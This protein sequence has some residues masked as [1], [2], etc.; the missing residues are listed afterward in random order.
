MGRTTDIDQLQ[1][2]IETQSEGAI[3]SLTELKKALS[4]LKR[5]GKS[6]ELDNLATKLEK[7]SKIRFDNLKQI[8]M[9]GETFKQVKRLTKDVD[10]LK[11][12]MATIG[13]NKGV[14]GAVESLTSGL[15][16]IPDKIDIP[17]NT[18]GADTAQT[19]TQNVVDGLIKSSS[20]SDI[21][22]MKLEGVK[23]KLATLA[24]DPDADKGAMANLIQ[25]AQKLQTELDKTSGKFKLF[26]KNAQSGTKK[27]QNG[28]MQLFK[29]VVLYGT[30]FRL[31]SAFTSGISEGLKNLSQYNNETSTAMNKL[32]TMSLQLK[33]S[34]GAALYPVI[35]AITPALQ[36]M[37]NAVIKALN[38]FNQFVASLSGAK[39][40][41][42]AKE[43]LKEYGDTA[44]KTADKI[45]KS[46][47][48]MD[49]ITVIGDKSGS[50]DSGDNPADMFEE[51]EID[52][53]IKDSL[54]TILG[55][56]GA[57]GAG[58]A[59]WAI[60]T[61]LIK[62][63]QWL[64]TIKPTDFSWSFSILGGVSFIADLNKLKDYL[65]DIS[66]NGLNFTN[67]TG[68][69][70]EFAGA[71]GD[72]LMMLGQLKWAGALKAV[73]GVGEIVSAVSDIA[74]NGVNIDNATTAVRGLSNLAI[75]VGL[76]TGNLK[77]AGAAT[78]IQGFTSIIG[79][80][81]KNWEAIKQGDWSGVDKATLVIGAIQALG[82]IVT[83]LGAFSKI[84]STVDTA[85][86]TK[87]LQDVSKTTENLT[88]TTSTLSS[89]LT[90]LAKN[91][92]LGIV[93][94]AE[95]A[96]AAGLIVA[97]IWGLGVLL[98]QV[99]KAW[100]PVLDNGG[101]IAAA[102]GIGLALLVAIGAVTVLLGT[103]G[104]TLVAP[105]AIGIAVLALIGAS[106]VL[107]LAEILV[108]GMMLNEIGIAWQPV[109]DNGENI[110]AAIGIGTALL[111]G[112]GAVTAALGVATVATAGALPLAIA[113][114]TALLVELALA[115][116]S[117]C[118]SLIDVANKLI[119]LSTP[120]DELNVILPG[121]KVDMDNF[122]SFMGDFAGAV[123]EFTAASAIAGIAATIDKVISFFTTDPVQRMYDEITDQTKEFENLIPALEKI[124]PLIKKAIDLVG[125]YKENMGSFS[126]ATGGSGG[127]LNSVVDGAKGVINGI[128]NLFEGMANGVIKCINFI[129]SGLNTISFD[130]PDWVP[131]IGGK[132]FGFNI[133][134][135]SEIS[136]PRFQT[137]GFPEDGL[138]MANHNE[139]VGRFSNGR[140]A[141]ANNEQIVDG[142]AGGV[143]AANQEQNGLLREQNKLL[144]QL[145]DN[146]S[147]GQIDVT[148]ITSAMQRK[149]RRD[150][151][152]IVPVGI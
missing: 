12:S 17:I 23:A 51:V 100:Q 25:K 84:K 1:I 49:E 40:F 92:A 32:S 2:Q 48:G 7:I 13:D 29:I 111:I 138:F 101:T 19:A 26:G 53:T 97:A 60:S 6:P 67:A 24:A 104:T 8:N 95:V 61:N 21:L 145:V 122:T 113:L 90:S 64:K 140:T 94:I 79:E 115:F 38:A 71:M 102:M 88:T 66:E 143:Y 4:S 78:A 44:K 107:F 46:F 15:S 5:Y 65:K 45:K 73:Q 59:T 39:T 108:V 47:A 57:I 77:L 58:F 129:I 103:L 91:L 132:T 135:F 56:V 106:A 81:G 72:V 20:A 131:V 14:G 36:Y 133:K 83:A 16:E 9:L 142:I 105:L 75:A 146:R 119:E 28:L 112:I 30:A 34:I 31:W 149:N 3:K 27:A 35:V 148:T 125:K 62:A 11:S 144:R 69:L 136:I 55:T 22:K 63:L 126:S 139:L 109:L 98:D 93:V 37:A 128:I 74:K 87:D 114:G 137:G 96:V 117:F 124:N 54:G 152:T 110:A 85:K 52:D 116:V 76:F 41:I 151:K 82:G 70:S 68:V 86:A 43:Y 141:V 118:D 121:L 99:G 120:L 127:F 150:G 18:P 130:V 123:V 147:N 50:S 80:L 10:N 33:N 89:K 42:R 134:Q